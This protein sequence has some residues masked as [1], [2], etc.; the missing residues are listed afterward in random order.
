MPRANE[1]PIIKTTVTHGSISKERET[2]PA[3]GVVKFSRCQGNPGKLF[4]SH[5]NNHAGVIRMEVSRAVRDHDLSS[6]W[7]HADEPLIELEL[8]FVQFAEVLT[9]MNMGEGVPCT[10]KMLQGRQPVPSIPMDMETEQEKVAAGFKREAKDFG[11]KVR[12]RFKEIE[13]ILAKPSIGKKDRD[14]IRSAMRMVLTDVEQNMPFVLESF[15]E[16][17]EKVAQAAKAEVEGFLTGVIHRAGLDGLKDRLL[18]LTDN[19]E[20]PDHTKP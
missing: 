4:G 1:E 11:Q 14:A 13:D 9:S 12:G 7:V 10:L 20:L 18:G 2:H 16:S 3:F 19:P 17:T 5:L 8:S 15:V 6:D